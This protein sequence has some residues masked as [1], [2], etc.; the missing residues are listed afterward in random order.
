MKILGDYSFYWGVLLGGEA[1]QG[2]KMGV[3]KTR[4]YFWVGGEIKK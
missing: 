2:I 4:A 3:Y 1:P